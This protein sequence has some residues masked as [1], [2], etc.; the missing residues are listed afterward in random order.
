MLIQVWTDSEESGGGIT[1]APKPG[2]DKLKE[3]N[4][5]GPNAKLIHEFE[6]ATWLEAMET[7]YRLMGWNPYK[8]QILDN[9]EID[10]VYLKPLEEAYDF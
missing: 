5:I 3:Q 8:P 9:G 6:A 2:C 10:P 7:Y 1:C 4:L